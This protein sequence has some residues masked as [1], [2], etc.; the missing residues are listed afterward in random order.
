MIDILQREL[1]SKLCSKLKDTY[2]WECEITEW[3]KCLPDEKDEKSKQLQ[4]IAYA[5]KLPVEQKI[6]IF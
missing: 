5:Y 3:D 4:E 6:K 2:Q 1:T